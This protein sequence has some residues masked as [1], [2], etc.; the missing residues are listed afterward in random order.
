MENH[1]RADNGERFLPALCGHLRRD[2]RRP[3]LELGILRGLPVP[4][5]K[6]Q[7]EEVQR[8]QV[9]SDLGEKALLPIPARCTKTH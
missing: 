2:C 4:A 3:R 8:Q 6:S 7:R 9:Y 1:N 5:K